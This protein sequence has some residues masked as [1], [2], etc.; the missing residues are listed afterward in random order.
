[1]NRCNLAEAPELSKK[2]HINRA[3]EFVIAEETKSV[4]RENLTH[5]YP[6]SL[7][8]GLRN[9]TGSPNSILMYNRS[10]E[11]ESRRSSAP[12]RRS[13]VLKEVERDQ[14]SMKQDPSS[15]FNHVRTLVSKK[16]RRYVIEGMDLDLTYIT[17]NLIAMGFPSEG[18]EGL[19]RNR[20]KDTQ[21]FF[22]TRHHNKYHIW[23]LCS[24]RN[25]NVDKFQGRVSPFPFDDHNCPPFDDMEPF[26]ESVDN[27]LSLDPENVAAMHCKAGKG[28]TGL[29]ICVYLLHTGTWM[30]AKS[31]LD[32]YAISRTRN[33]KGV[34]IPSQRRWVKYYEI[35]LKRKAL[36]QFRASKRY[37]M[38]SV[39][40]SKSCPS[41]TE[42]VVYNEKTQ[43]YKPN[44]NFGKVT[45]LNTREYKHPELG[46][47]ILLKCPPDLIIYKDVKVKW[48][49]KGKIKKGKS[50]VFSVWFNTDFIENNRL[51]LDKKEIDKVNKQKKVE[52]FIVCFEFD[53]LDDQKDAVELGQQLRYHES[54]KAPS[55]GDDEFDEKFENNGQ[56]YQ[57]SNCCK[58]SSDVTRKEQK[59]PRNED[60]VAQITT[61]D[62]LVMSATES[63][64]P[65]GFELL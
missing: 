18:L 61:G 21:K 53:P 50:R 40:V 31:A 28:R 11:K 57:F 33:M 22:N 37:R 42:M 63:I 58:A 17:K 34:T 15:F 4:W 46:E 43:T 24:E 27:W 32:F 59:E 47:G 9:S 51:L 10:E 7:N 3:T 12:V 5:T 64:L 19:Y 2:E 52:D 23:N 65:R 29:M 8:L 30:D 49:V 39:F 48:S 35:M 45:S 14:V 44:E 20:M 62:K 25:Y 1:M 6:N 36:G 56:L 26:C 16:K 38:R 54:N 60:K 41:F 55:K 13:A